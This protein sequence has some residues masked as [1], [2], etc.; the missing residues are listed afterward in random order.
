MERCLLFFFFQQY[1]WYLSHLTQHWK[2]FLLCFKP[3]FEYIYFLWTEFST[4]M[5]KFSLKERSTW[6]ILNLLRRW[7][8]GT[9]KSW[10]S[11]KSF[12][13]F[14]RKGFL[15]LHLYK[16]LWIYYNSPICRHTYPGIGCFSIHWGRKKKIFFPQNTGMTW[17]AIPAEIHAYPNAVYCM[18]TVTFFS[19]GEIL[20]LFPRVALLYHLALMY[21]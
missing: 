8:G 15:L 12:C 10:L 7:M 3:R 5:I 13:R 20:N 21:Y 1:I 17:T 9:A 2:H 16:H 14:S 6:C 18:H 4:N 11:K 19:N